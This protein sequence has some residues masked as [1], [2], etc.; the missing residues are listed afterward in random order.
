MEEKEYIISIQLNWENVVLSES[1][2]QAIKD[3]KNIFEEQ[4]NL[5]LEDSEIKSVE[6]N[7]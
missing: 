1:M 7:E 3:I 2:E 5:V 4:H 6:L